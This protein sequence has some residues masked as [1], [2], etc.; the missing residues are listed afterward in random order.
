MLTKSLNQPLHNL[1][2]E[3]TP[4]LMACKKSNYLIARLL[5]NTSPKLMFLQ[6]A[7]SQLSTLHVACSREDVKMVRMI[8]DQMSLLIQRGDFD[9]EKQ[10]D[11]DLRDN[12]GH[13]PFFNACYYGYTEIV[14]MF[15]DFQVEYSRIVT[16]NVNAAL[17]QTQCTPLHAAVRKGN[18]EIVR[19]LLKSKDI[20]VNVEVRPS[21]K[22]HQRLIRVLQK[23]LHGRILPVQ[24]SVDEER[25]STP[26]I[27]QS[28]PQMQRPHLPAWNHTLQ[29]RGALDLSHQRPWVQREQ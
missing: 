26:Q 1:N 14:K 15:I 18:N 17:K 24:D 16:L 6:E 2:N 25:G 5:L 4:L 20:E 8:L 12:L 29:S 28:E 11:L 13:T 3:D 21:S 9:D 22:T 27:V 23:K 10:L 7:Q 19:M